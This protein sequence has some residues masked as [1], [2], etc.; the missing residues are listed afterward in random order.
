M[1]YGKDAKGNGVLGYP[2]TF[3][4][5]HDTTGESAAMNGAA[6]IPNSIFA[7]FELGFALLSAGIVTSSVAGRIQLNGFLFFMFVWHLVV[8]SPVAHVTWNPRGAFATN[9]IMDFS[10]AL[11]VH[12]L[13]AL[14]ALVLH[15]VLGKDAIPASKPVAEPEKALFWVLIVWFLWFGFNAGKAHA[16]NSVAAQSIVN[17]IAATTTSIITSFFYNIILEKPNNSTTLIY[18]ILIGLIAITPASG[19]VTVGGAMVIAIFT[20]GFTVFVSQFVIGENAAENQPFS[21]VSTHAIAGAVGFLWTAIISYKFV[22]AAGENG[23]TYG[24]GTSLAY[25]ISFL[26]ALWGCAT[27][28]VALIAFIANLLFPMGNGVIPAE[29]E[30]ADSTPAEPVSEKQVEGSGLELNTV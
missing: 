30:N 21:I 23:L 19:F 4:M 9:H 8:Y 17:T 6:N 29:Y 28:S 14:T 7:V 5:F 15:V 16:A 18:A 10:G 20:Y 24:R 25:H 1:V 22:N 11:P 3:Y 12:S 27:I 26:L 13:A 2:G